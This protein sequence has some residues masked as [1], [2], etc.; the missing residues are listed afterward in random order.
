MLMDATLKVVGWKSD[1]ESVTKWLRRFRRTSFLRTHKRREEGAQLGIH[2]LS[3]AC[4][5]LDKSPDQLV[6][7]ARSLQPGET[8]EAFIALEEAMGKPGQSNYDVALR[9]IEWLT[10]EDFFKANGIRVLAGE[11][12]Y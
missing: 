5:R 10:L 4:A 2:A 3:N 6:Y 8:V 11:K 9:M 1:Y 12:S 7:E